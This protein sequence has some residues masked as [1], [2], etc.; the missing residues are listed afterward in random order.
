M[1]EIQ[2]SFLENVRQTSVRRL[3]HLGRGLPT[4]LLVQINLG[5]FQQTSH[6]L[7]GVLLLGLVVVVLAEADS[8]HESGVTSIVLV[9][10]KK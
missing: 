5:M 10:K 7:L 8:S 1:I 6:N 9:E 3:Q 2:K 4:S